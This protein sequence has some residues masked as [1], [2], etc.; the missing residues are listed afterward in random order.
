MHTQGK[1]WKPNDKQMKAMKTKANYGKP[2]KT[3]GDNGKAKK[4]MKIKLSHGK[5]TESM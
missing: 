1:Q 5:P 3:E 4:Y 2:M